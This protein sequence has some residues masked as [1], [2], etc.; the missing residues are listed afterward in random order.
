M[1]ALADKVSTLID[2]VHQ[3]AK[4]VRAL[5]DAVIK[6]DGGIGRSSTY[7]APCAQG[8]RGD[9]GNGNDRQKCG[10]RDP[11]SGSKIVG[12]D[13]LPPLEQFSVPPGAEEVRQD[14][15]SIHFEDILTND[16]LKKILK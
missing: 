4:L 11:V 10:D 12:G 8:R 15:M 14:L 3:L 1:L 9:I 16:E 6:V 13:P 5:A 2:N 7:C